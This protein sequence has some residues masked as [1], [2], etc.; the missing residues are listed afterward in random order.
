MIERFTVDTV[1][2][3]IHWLFPLLKNVQ[4]K[5]LKNVSIRIKSRN[6]DTFPVNMANGWEDLGR[7]LGEGGLTSLMHWT[8]ELNGGLQ[9]PTRAN[10]FYT[11]AS[12]RLAFLPLVDRLSWQCK[13]LFDVFQ[14][15]WHDNS[16]E[17]GYHEGGRGI[18]MGW[19]P[20]H[21]LAMP[22]LP[23]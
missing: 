14:E 5:K 22:A 1:F 9:L 16:R 10:I 4:W 21:A 11:D 23:I 2:G 17:E 18:D 7:W 20:G 19:L 13:V 3:A 8:L 12:F 6:A 15:L